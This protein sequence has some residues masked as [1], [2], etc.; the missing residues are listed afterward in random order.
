MKKIK[1]LLTA[2]IALFAVLVQGQETESA[3]GFGQILLIVNVMLLLLALVLI[4][5][6]NYAIRQLKQGAKSENKIQLTWWERFTALKSEKTEEELD[7]HE[8]YDGITELDNPP[9]P[10]FNFIFYITIFFGIVYLINYH[11]I[12]YSD[13]QEAEYEKEIAKAQ[14]E[15]ENYLK[16]VGNLIDENN[17]TLLADNKSL[18]E[19]KKVFMANCKVCHGEYGEGLVG[20]NL[21]DEYWL[22]GNTINDIFKVVKYGVP[23][24]GM[25][26]WQNS[27]TPLQIQQVSSY[28]KSLYGTNPKNPKEPQGTKMEDNT[29]T[30]PDS[31]QNA[32]AVALK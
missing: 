5:M 30:Q 29:N 24:K 27:L 25:V 32:G 23:Q 31:T 11:V 22:H 2:S 15:K 17:V 7:M 4:N 1:L 20:P 26:P 14:K 8:N 21:T 10:W 28:V 9:P 6:L 3:T 19:G 18:E 16:K 12:G 13:L